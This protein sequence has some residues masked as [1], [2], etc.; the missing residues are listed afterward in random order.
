M[1]HEKVWELISNLYVYITVNEAPVLE[2]VQYQLN[3]LTEFSKCELVWEG[4]GEN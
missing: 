4:K 2:M 3:R 1:L